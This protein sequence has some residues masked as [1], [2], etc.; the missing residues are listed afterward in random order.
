MLNYLY[1]KNALEKNNV[2][3]V[4]L[5]E[6]VQ[7]MLTDLSIVSEG[8][9]FNSGIDRN[10]IRKNCCKRSYL[11]GAFL[12]GGSVN[13]PEGSSYHLEIASM[14]EE[15]CQALVELANGF[16]L[17]ARCIERKKVLFLYQGRREN[18]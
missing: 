2:Y 16:N 9:M 10:I 12:A 3:I 8:F 6:K 1:V 18:H 14:Y 5:P 7:D 11:R 17:N 4:R 15:H 13:N